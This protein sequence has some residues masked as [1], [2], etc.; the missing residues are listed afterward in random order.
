M[1]LKYILS[2]LI[3]FSS[4]FSYSQGADLLIEYNIFMM[5]GMPTMKTGQLISNGN[6]SI[7][8]IK[9]NKDQELTTFPQPQKILVQAKTGDTYFYT[10]FM[11]KK[12]ISTAY[13]DQKIYKMN[14]ELVSINWKLIVNDSKIITN[15]KCLKAIGEFR[16]RKYIAWYSPDIPINS[17]PWKFNGLPGL[18]LE[19]EDIDNKF[20]WVATEIKYPYKGDIPLE[21]P[22]SEKYIELSL[23]EFVQIKEDFLEDRQ[24]RMLSRTPKGVTVVSSTHERG[25]ELVYEWE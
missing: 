25:F 20:Q 11:N 23:E 12:L 9:G 6:E 4:T 14:E 18:I 8:K 3:L 1:N 22:K 19:I 16:G 5:P 7:F 2:F 15:F 13:L 10:D 17:G 24:S 21:I